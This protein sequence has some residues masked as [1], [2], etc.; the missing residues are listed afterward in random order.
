MTAGHLDSKV[1]PTTLLNELLKGRLHVSLD[2]FKMSHERMLQHQLV[3]SSEIRPLN[4]HLA[5]WSAHKDA[6]HMDHNDSV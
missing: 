4:Q 2:S 5:L 6:H 1:L 3:N